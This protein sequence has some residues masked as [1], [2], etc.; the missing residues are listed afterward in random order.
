MFLEYPVFDWSWTFSRCITYHHHHLLYRL[1]WCVGGRILFSSPPHIETSETYPPVNKTLPTVPLPDRKLNRPDICQTQA[2]S[3]S[4]PSVNAKINY[5]LSLHYQIN[6]NRIDAIKKIGI[7]FG[8]STSRQILVYALQINGHHGNIMTVHFQHHHSGQYASSSAHYC[9]DI[10]T[11]SP[12]VS[13]WMYSLLGFRY[14]EVT[15]PQNKFYMP[16]LSPFILSDYT[17]RS[18]ASDGKRFLAVPS[19]RQQPKSSL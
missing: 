1:C 5:P 17:P 18:H 14:T 6:S 3:E 15:I 12:A 9:V 13:W 7:S 8:R 4:E 19:S 11:F 10:Q 2:K 16:R